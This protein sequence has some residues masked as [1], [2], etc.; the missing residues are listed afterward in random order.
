M[1]IPDGGPGTLT[2]NCSFEA[3]CDTVE[4]GALW[5]PYDANLCV[6]A[7]CHSSAECASGQRCVAPPLLVTQAA[8]STSGAGGQSGASSR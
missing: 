6:R 4:C 2:A 7:L 5:S 3:A 8:E 1:A